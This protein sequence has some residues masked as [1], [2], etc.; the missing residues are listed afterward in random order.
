MCIRDSPL[1]FQNALPDCLCHISSRRYSPLS[2][3]VVEKRSKCKSFW[4]PIFVGGAAPTFLREFVRA[5]YDPLLGKVWLSS[6]CWSPSAKPGNEAE[7]RIYGGWV[8]GGRVWSRLWTKV[9]D[10]LGRY[11]RPLVIVNAF[12][13]LSICVF[14]SEDIGPVSYTHLTLPTNREV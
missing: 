6:V 12:D 7:Y 14:S 11:R 1:Y 9:H 2:L 4:L 3:E 13:W 5:T 8:N 10:I